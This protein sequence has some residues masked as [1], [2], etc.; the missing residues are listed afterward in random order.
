MRHCSSL[1]IC[2]WK[3]ITR[4]GSSI[5]NISSLEDELKHTNALPEKKRKHWTTLFPSWWSGWASAENTSSPFTTSLGWLA[6]QSPFFTQRHFG[7]TV[8]LNLRL[9]DLILGIVGYWKK[10]I[11]F[12]TDF[13]TYAKYFTWKNSWKDPSGAYMAIICEPIRNYIRARPDSAEVIVLVI[14]SVWLCTRYVTS[15]DSSS[16]S[17]RK[18]LPSLILRWSRFLDLVFEVLLMNYVQ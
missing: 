13:S 9:F 3:I 5:F 16:F 6:S 2:S 10:S 12:F 18:G 17:F 14:S 1:T 15:I 8:A 4:R 7:K 11:S